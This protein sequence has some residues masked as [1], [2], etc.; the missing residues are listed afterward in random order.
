MTANPARPPQF[1]L[2]W[3]LAYLTAMSLVSAGL[4]YGR[5]E[6]LRT[7]DTSTSRAEWTTWRDD[8]QKSQAG[9]VVRRRVPKSIEP[10][11]VVLMRDYFGVCLAISLVLSSILFA[12]FSFFLRGALST[13]TVGAIRRPSTDS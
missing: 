12:T 7:Y 9:A 11:A 10:P 3:L 6:A 13:P 1:S 8:V 2:A 5:R 4:V